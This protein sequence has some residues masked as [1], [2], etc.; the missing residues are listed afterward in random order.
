V[1]KLWITVDL[2]SKSVVS[3]KL[4]VFY[5]YLEGVGGD[6]VLVCAKI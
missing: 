2:K 4:F 3:E 1:E 5:T 6:E